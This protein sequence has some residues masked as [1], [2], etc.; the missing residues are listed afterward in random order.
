MSLHPPH[1]IIIYNE[2]TRPSFVSLCLVSLLYA[3]C[4]WQL[5]GKGCHA[6]VCWFPHSHVMTGSQAWPTWSA[7]VIGGLVH[8]VM[9]VMVMVRQTPPLFPLPSSPF[10]P[11]SLLSPISFL[12]SP[13]FSSLSYHPSPTRTKPSPFH[14]KQHLINQVL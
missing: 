4:G 13:S 10:F 6:T 5:S 12:P 9:M 8:G 3:C 14:K 11:F 7:N 2:Q 1:L